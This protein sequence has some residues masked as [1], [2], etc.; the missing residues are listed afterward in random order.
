MVNRI[1]GIL[2][3][4]AFAMTAFIGAVEADNSFATTIGRALLAMLG[5]YVIGY[6]VGM[7]ADRMLAENL[8]KL[9]ER[10][11]A[12]RSAKMAERAKL[13]ESVQE[14]ATDGR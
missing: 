14:S 3:L 9:E 11:A 7:A 5:T 13:L 6:L 2:A 8:S 1:A 12:E 4:V 10:L